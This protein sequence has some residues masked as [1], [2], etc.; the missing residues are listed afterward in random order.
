MA[1]VPRHVW[2]QASLRALCLWILLTSFA[3]AQESLPF[4]QPEPVPVSVLPPM[5]DDQL[6]QAYAFG[7]AHAGQPVEV[8]LPH[9]FVAA[10]GGWAIVST[11]WAEAALSG[12]YEGMPNEVPSQELAFLRRLDGV[13]LI[14]TA[15][16]WHIEIRQEDEWVPTLEVAALDGVRFTFY[17]RADLDESM[18]VEVAFF[19]GEQPVEVAVWDWTTL[20]EGARVV[21]AVERTPPPPPLEWVGFDPSR[22]EAVYRMGEYTLTLSLADAGFDTTSATLRVP[23]RAERA[24][25]G[26]WEFALS[27]AP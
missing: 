7:R 8:L 1:V 21:P 20:A 2:H 14:R 19:A 25:D 16:T 22:A 27:P 17:R 18:P 10:G 13:L 24:G 23:A 15:D 6:H 11:Q 5:S 3:G 26:Q 9:Y 4:L 12:W